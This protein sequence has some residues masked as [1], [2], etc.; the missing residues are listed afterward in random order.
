MR[1]AW[2]LS[3]L[4]LAL[5]LTILVAIRF[6]PLPLS[7]TEAP[8]AGIRFTDRNGT[9]LRESLLEGGR[10]GAPISIDKLPPQL[11][12][13]TICAED[14]R[15]WSHHG[16]DPLAV[17]RAVLD[18][19]RHGRIVSGASTISQQ[20]IKIVQPRPRNLG[21]K[22][23]EALQ[24]LRLEQT[25]SKRQILE[26]YL[27]R[28]D[29][30]NFR[31]GIASA[32]EYYF[33]KPPNDLSLAE[34][35]FLAGLPQAPSRLNP[36]RHL[37]RARERQRQVLAR[38]KNE[39]LVSQTAC[40]RALAEPVRLAL[41]PANF[42]APHFVD[43]VRQER[44]LPPARTVQ[45]T[46]DLPLTKFC[47]RSLRHHLE[48]LRDQQVKNGAVVVIENRTGNVIALVGSQD[49]FGPVAGQVNGAWAARS[50]GSAIK[51]FTY[52]LAFENGATPASVVADV[53]VAFTTATG[54]Y[55]PENYNHL[56]YGPVRLRLALAN[57]LN[58]PAV[59]VLASV[60]GAKPLQELLRRCGISTLRRPAA[61]YGLGLTIGNANVRLLELVNAYAALARLGE[62]QPYRLL[63]AEPSAPL[64]RIGDASACY[65]LADILS[66]NAARALTF[67][68]NSWLRFDFP[69]A[70][71]TGTSTSFR[72]NWA[73]AY[74]PEFT[75]GVWVGNFDG[76]AMRDVSGV[77]GAAP[78]LHEVV[79]HLQR[80]FGTT[81]YAPP[82]DIVER[83]VRPLT[84]K[85]VAVAEEKTAGLVR[86]KFVARHLPPLESPDDYDAM[87]RVKLGPEYQDWLGSAQNE[88]AGQVAPARLPNEHL[89]VVSPL[90]GS[91]Y[92][93]DPDLLQSDRLPL[94]SNASGPHVWKS[95]TLQ[96]DD[97]FAHLKE[98]RHEITLLD[99]ATGARA[100]TWIL[101]KAL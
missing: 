58:I 62:F 32:A 73:I 28:V 39:G 47:Q 19:I 49:Y 82:P 55:R 12:A 71:K 13:A 99:P 8:A 95:A 86:E 64:R 21:T 37:V 46:L 22:L 80:E 36:R 5:C 83:F 26:A 72:D 48:K 101:V 90:P 89:R 34:C 1:T 75:A 59:K 52:L 84:G 42:D 15:F 27:D 29:Y 88:L 66:D 41:R 79:E 31:L 3:L 65:L 18:A 9:V 67:G 20:L 61:K 6:V 16:V 24:A 98:G 54:V 45:T 30:G 53:P 43:L 96:C 85:R 25:W 35:A 78:I 14:K 23:I 40:A 17:S 76:S 97:S 10:L 56:C 63:R 7:L 94:Q 33:G 57:S 70:V 38:M 77:S 87:G 69:V 2:R 60:G 51:P 74:T 68:T 100:E 81:W 93:L 11:L 92:Y 50:A 44:A 4:V 91:V